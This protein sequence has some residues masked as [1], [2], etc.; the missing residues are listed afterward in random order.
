MLPQKLQYERFYDIILRG[1]T[2][3]VRI[4]TWNYL[5]VKNARQSIE[6]KYIFDMVRL[7]T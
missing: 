4:A 5:R 3:K 1:K 2:I 7:K 6:R